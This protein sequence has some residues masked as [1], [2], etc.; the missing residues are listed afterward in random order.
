MFLQENRQKN[1][2]VNKDLSE[3]EVVSLLYHSIFNY[4]LKQE[5]LIKWTVGEKVLEIFNKEKIYQSALKIRQKDKYFYFGYQGALIFQRLLKRR[6]SDRKKSLARK[7][8]RILGFIPTIRFIGLTGALAMDNSDENSDI[9]LLIIV[10][11]NTLWTTR[12]ISYLILKFF[13][14]TIRRFEKK[15]TALGQKD[16]LCLNM[17]LDESSLVWRG[18]RDLFTSHEIA[19][20]VPLIN[21]KGIYEKLINKNQWLKDFWPNAILIRNSKTFSPPVEVSLSPFIVFEPLAYKFQRWYMKGKVT[22]EVVAQHKAIFHP[23]D[24]D[25]IVN[26]RLTLWL[27]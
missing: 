3:N 26:S 5:E 16:K 23:F 19:Q 20:I 22:R 8:S 17:W 9:D 21:K 24:W 27:T 12:L 14:M 13:G 10:S 25:K 6:I 11:K 2:I 15:P 18:K 1:K 4:P 7:A